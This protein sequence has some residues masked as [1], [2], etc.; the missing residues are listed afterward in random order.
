MS[1]RTQTAKQNHC[2]DRPRRISWVF[3]VPV[4]TEAVNTELRQQNDALRFTSEAL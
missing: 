4:D 3:A 1:K 2:F